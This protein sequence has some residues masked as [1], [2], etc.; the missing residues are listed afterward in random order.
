MKIS[1]SLPDAD[2]EFIDRYAECHDVKTRSSVLHKAVKLL[3]EDDL[4]DAYEEAFIEWEESGEG[5]VWDRALR[6]GLED[7]RYEAR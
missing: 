7:D 4:G 5:A 1:V 6:D 2:I 3:Q